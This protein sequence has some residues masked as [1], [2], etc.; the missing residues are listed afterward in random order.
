[1]KTTTE[2]IH[3]WRHLFIDVE[4]EMMYH[5]RISH[6]KL[7]RRLGNFALEMEVAMM[8]RREAERAE[9]YF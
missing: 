3:A 9:A 6:M 1:M 7:L 8:K 2:S 4:F 5:S